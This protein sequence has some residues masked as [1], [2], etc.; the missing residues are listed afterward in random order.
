MCQYFITRLPAILGRTHKGHD[1]NFVGLGASKA[2]SRNHC[3]IY[4]RDVHGGRIHQRDG[5]D[6][7]FYSPKQKRLKAPT[8]TATNLG[9]KEED[10]DEEVEAKDIILPTNYSD[11]APSSIEEASKK[12]DSGLPPHGF[13][14]VK[15]LGKN[16]IIVGGK[17]V[18]KGQVA[19]LT[20]KI[21]LQ[22][23]SYKLYFLLP[24]HS[25]EN[26]QNPSI[27]E[28]PNPE[29]EAY[30]SATL[31]SKTVRKR[32]I[33]PYSGTSAAAHDEDE[34]SVEELM[35]K[36][37]DAI[38]ANQWDRRQQM[39]GTTIAHHAV[40]DAA[41]S[42]ECQKIA[43]KMNG[44]VSRYAVAYSLSPCS[45]SSFMYKYCVSHSQYLC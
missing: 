41:K 42:T 29:Y 21:T 11:I 2:L 16:K 39:L 4:Y 5:A 13:F 37:S 36:M 26:D 9:T 12:D 30:I 33:E 35:Q 1:L 27:L 7:F 43:K 19:I 28:I 20:D 38:K 17:T 22:L 25:D 23:A 15:C 8:T 44:T 31:K 40:L 3:I 14:V 10:D 45:F 6:D 24:L 34:L 18:S 32:S